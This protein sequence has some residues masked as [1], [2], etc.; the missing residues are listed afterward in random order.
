MQ[1]IKKRHWELKHNSQCTKAVK[2]SHKMFP[3][4]IN[5]NFTEGEDEQ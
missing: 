4:T 5:I 2:L 3:K 1:E